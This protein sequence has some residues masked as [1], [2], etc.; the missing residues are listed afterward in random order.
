MK[1]IA[2]FVL[3]LL[4]ALPIGA[5]VSS[6]ETKT[7]N[8]N[9]VRVLIGFDKSVG[10]SEQALVQAF[11]GKIKYSYSVVN[12]IAAQIPQSAIEGLS[13]NPHVSAVEVDDTVYAVDIELDNAW[14]VKHIQ[15]GDVHATPYSNKG[16]G[17]KIGII[18]SGVNYLHPDLIDNFNPLNL[19][20]D[21]YYYD[22]DPMDVYGHGTHVAGTACAED[23]DNGL[24]SPKLGVVG[25]ASE[26]ELYSLRVLNNDGVGYWSDIIASVDWSTGQSIYLP[27]YWDTDVGAPEEPIQGVKMD[28]INLSLGKDADPGTIVKQSF[29]NAYNDYGVLIIA[30]AGNSGNKGGKNE[31]TIY[32]AKFDSVIAVGATDSSNKRATFSSTGVAVEIVAPGVDVY[33]T[34]NDNTGYYNPQPT[35]TGVLTD[36]NGDGE[37][38]GECYK[39]GSGTSMASPHVAG[40]AALVIKA[41]RDAGVA[42]TNSDVRA[43][44]QATSQDLGSFGRD[45]QYGYGLVNAVAAV[46]ATDPNTNNAPT[47]D[48]GADQTVVDSDANGTENVTLDG[49]GS[50][51]SDGT[52]DLY[53]WYEGAT[54]LSNLISPTII[55]AVGNHTVTLTVT[56][57]DGVTANDTVQINITEE[58]SGGTNCP[59][60]KA[61][62]GLCT[63]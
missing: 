58:S 33:S 45:I 3:V 20:Y 8:D 42:Y 13:H 26:C 47:A 63:P 41:F 15:A 53:A 59:P 22:D 1:N 25:V 16:A 36:I 32:P 51:D 37:P 60:G 28:V 52:V 54:F 23:N 11:G 50:S 31:S 2:I 4:I 55:F 12:A 17:V 24:A 56:D 30:A 44:L 57:D 39:Y 48:A 34:W 14:G 46:Q 6:A 35:C 7:P 38:D 49:S 40:V 21:F 43:I 18:D 62:K 29:D 19:G 5:S 9:L 10:A 61:K 27:S